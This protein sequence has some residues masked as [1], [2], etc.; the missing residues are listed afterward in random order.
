M[1]T[2]KQT[3]M[4]LIELM[5]VVAI[6][7]ILAGIGIPAYERYTTSAA[8]TTGKTA[9]QTVRAKLENY[10]INNK[11]YTTDISKLG[12]T[13]SSPSLNKAG[14]ETTGSDAVYTISISNPGGCT[15][16]SCYT[17]TATPVNAQASND[18]DCINLTLTLLGVKN[19]S[20]PNGVSCWN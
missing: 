8:R 5:I 19:A 17:L 20:G 4:T 11:A 13:A 16:A 14:D 2:H 18:T 9:L 12:Y 1:T 6:V 3:G 7:G 15:L 10:Y